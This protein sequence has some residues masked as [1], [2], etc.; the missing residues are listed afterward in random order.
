MQACTHD[1]S[2]IL[3]RNQRIR[4]PHRARHGIDRASVASGE[5]AHKSP[6]K[7]QCRSECSIGRSRALNRLCFTCNADRLRVQ[8]NVMAPLSQHCAYLVNRVTAQDESSPALHG[9]SLRATAIYH[10]LQNPMA[11][12]S[13]SSHYRML[14]ASSSEDAT[15]KSTAAGV[16]V[17][18]TTTAG[19]VG[20]RHPPCQHSL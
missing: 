6:G 14:H 3:Q 12:Y 10:M 1:S 4:R 11:S 8:G 13:S 2:A 9:S 7:G 18:P 5:T 16:L 17:E 19:Q 20:P 15:L